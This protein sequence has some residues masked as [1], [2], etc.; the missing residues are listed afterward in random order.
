V[1]RA[2]MTEFPVMY[3]PVARLITELDLVVARNAP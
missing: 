3:L 2:V 1:R